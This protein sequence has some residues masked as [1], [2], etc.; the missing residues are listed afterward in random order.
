[1]VEALR[2]EKDATERKLEKVSSENFD[3]SKE[4]ALLK[5]EKSNEISE[6]KAELKLKAFEIMTLG[7]KFEVTILQMCP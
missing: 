4:L 1:M 7:V 3:M 6:M 2:S 5:I